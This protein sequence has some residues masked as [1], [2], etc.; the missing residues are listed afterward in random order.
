MA[1]AVAVAGVASLLT[2]I[3]WPRRSRGVG[4]S[5][6]WCAGFAFA[7]AGTPVYNRLCPEFVFTWP[8]CLFVAHQVA[9][10]T[11]VWAGREAHG[12]K[13]RRLSLLATL[14]F[15]GVCLAYYLVCRR[16]SLVTEW[17]FLLGFLPCWPLAVP[18]A[19]RLHRDRPVWVEFLWAAAAFSVYFWAAG[20]ILIWK[21]MTT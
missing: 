16:L 19:R 21:A 8:V 17:V 9:L 5:L 3:R 2:S 15:L 20:G 12:R 14:F 7:A 11:I 13:P 10:N 6:F 4:R 18:A 1:V